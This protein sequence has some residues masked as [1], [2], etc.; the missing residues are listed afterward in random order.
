VSTTAQMFT[1][2]A[3]TN[4]KELVMSSGGFF[5][6]TAALSLPSLVLEGR[7]LRMRGVWSADGQP[8]RV[9]GNSV[10]M[11]LKVAAGGVLVQEVSRGS[12]AAGGVEVWR[13]AGRLGL[14]AH[15]STSPWPTTSAVGN[16]PSG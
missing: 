12:V 16:G 5:N 15:P 11:L 9:H 4:I 1:A 8:T 7:E 2:I 10:A 3:N 13:G 14:P 6:I